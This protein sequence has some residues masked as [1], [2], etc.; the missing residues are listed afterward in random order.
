[1]RSILLYLIIFQSYQSSIQNLSEN[2]MIFLKKKKTEPASTVLDSIIDCHWRIIN[3]ND[4][5]LEI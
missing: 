5:K 3:K 4:V 1:M 2:D